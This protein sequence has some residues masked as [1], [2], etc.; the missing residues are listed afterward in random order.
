MLIKGQ[1]ISG[2]VKCKRLIDTVIQLITIYHILENQNDYRFCVFSIYI[3]I[4]TKEIS[5]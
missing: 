1:K 5:M 3:K 2:D 4:P